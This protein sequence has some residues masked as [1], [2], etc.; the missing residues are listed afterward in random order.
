M[1]PPAPRVAQD[2]ES[3]DPN[4]VGGPTNPLLE[5]GGLSTII[6]K[7][8]DGDNSYMLNRIHT[9]RWVACKGALARQAPACSAPPSIRHFCS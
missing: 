8:R 5:G 4:R 3:T 6:G 1:P 2:K 9:R 7:S